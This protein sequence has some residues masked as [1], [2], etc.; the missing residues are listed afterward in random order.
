MQDIT[1]LSVRELASRVGRHEL[2]A[3]S[4]AQAYIDR[5]QALEP[6]IQAW[7]HFDPSYAIEQAREID[8]SA[9]SRPLVGVPI[10]VKDVL[11]TCDMPSSYGSSIYSEHRPKT[12]AAVV[13]SVR[14]AGAVIF[15]KTVTTE[16]ATFK[17]G[18]TVNPHS[19]E[20]EQPH[21]PGGSSSGSAAAVAAGMVPVAFATQTAASIVRP[22]AYC[23][24]VGYKP[25]FNTLPTAGV[26]L[27]SPS[28]DTIGVLARSVDDAAF[29]AGTIARRVFQL[30]TGS[31]LRVGLCRTPHWEQAEEPSREAVLS[32]A[33]LYERLGATVA[34]VRLP[35]ECD[36]L[37]ETHAGIMSFETLLALAPEAMTHG[38]ELSKP[39]L[40]VLEAGDALG[41]NGYVALLKQAEDAR[42]ATR[43][44][45]DSFDILIAPSAVGEAPVGI[46][47]TGD[48]IFGRIW[49][50]LGNPCVHVPTGV[51]PRGLPVGVTIIGARWDDQ[52]TLSAAAILE[53]MVTRR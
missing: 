18:C 15:G 49:T 26:K 25:T 1:S 5:I 6:R 16:F 32:A 19:L 46:G 42:Q 30:D 9:S 29:V 36:H 50:L 14:S 31:R 2:S 3:E 28:L 52:V 34:D 24:V 12:D 33:K 27:L 48:P 11:D 13:A 21:T 45:F 7:Q 47:Y 40:S 4:V 20:F 41:G 22:A 38:D 44:A 23:G 8:R 43:S 17:P 35:S 51:G 39:L 10:G 53:S 37:V